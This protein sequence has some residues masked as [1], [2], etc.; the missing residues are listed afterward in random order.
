MS[1][2][3][4]CRKPC[5]GAAEFCESC[6]SLLH[7]QLWQ[8]ASTVR[9]IDPPQAAES[10]GASGASLER[11]TAPQAL[12]DASLLHPEMPVHEQM[13]DQVFQQLHAAARQL[14]EAGNHRR[15]P[16]APRLSPLRDISIEIQRHSTPLRRVENAPEQEPGEEQA[17]NVYERWPLP[18]IDE[19]DEDENDIWSNHTDPLIRRH[20][21]N[22]AEVTRIEE[23]DLQRAIAEGLA[24]APLLA[25][26]ALPRQRT[27]RVAFAIFLVLAAAFLI[28]DSV[29]LF[30]VFAHPQRNAATHNGPPSLILSANVATAG[31]SLTLHIRHF[32]AQTRVY[33]THDIQESLQIIR[34]SSLLAVDASGS[35][36]V[37]MLVDATW[38]PGF[39]TIEA[40]DVATRYTASATLQIAGAGPTRPAHLLIDSTTLDLGAD[41][42]GANTL[43]T[44]TL[45]NSG[46]GSISWSASSNQAWLL[47]S[48]PQG[49]F[50][51]SQTIT[52]AVERANLKPG[53][54]KGTITF[55]SNV[56]ASEFVQVQMTVRPLPANV[57]PFLQLTP[58]V[59]SFTALDGGPSP[60]NQSLMISNPGTQ[61]LYWSLSSNNQLDL[62]SMGLA[63]NGLDP[64]TGWLTL[65]Q[66]SGVVVPHGSSLISA[67]VNSH[68]LLPGV[69]TDLLVF[70]AGH[71]VIDSP[72]RVSVSLTVQPHCGLTLNAGSIA[73]TAV[74][75]QSN[76]SNQAVGLGATSSCAGVINWRAISFANWL[77]ATPASGQLKG[78][79]NAVSA[80]S[81]SAS[82]LRP[83][84]Y[85]STLDFVTAQSTHTLSVQ[86]TVQ[87]PPS[88]SAPIMGATPL[89]LNFST[90]QGMPNP[91]GQTVTITNTGRSTLGWHTVVSSMATSWLVTSPAGGSIPAGQ[92]VQLTININTAGLSPNTYMGQVVL[93]GSDANGMAAAGT[94]QTITVNLQVLPPCALQ[95]PSL[96]SMAFS[97]TQGNADP[98]PQPMVITATGNC[99]W[100]LS[101]HATIANAPTWLSLS[102]TAGSFTAS[103]QSI[104]LQVAAS[105]AGLAAGTYTSKV[106]LRA[107][108]SS[109]TSVI[110]TPRVFS[111]TLTVLPP[112]T[113][114]MMGA[115]NFSFSVPQGQASSTPQSFAFSESGT[116]AGPLGWTASGDAGSSD[117]LILAPTSGSGRGSVT[118]SVN[119]QSFAPGTYLGTVTLTAI[120]SGGAVV[121]GSPQSIPVTLTVTGYGLSGTV[122]ACSDTSCTSSQPLPGASLS[123]VNSVNQAMTVV[124]DNAGNYSFS[125]LALG[126][127]TLT[128]SGSAGTTSYKGS[129]SLSITGN[130][131]NFSIQC[132]PLVGP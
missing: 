118:V 54:Y 72:Q 116:C 109:N 39:H 131:T 86:L 93:N 84:T 99:S 117:W 42:Q 108:D 5:E 48:P 125:N 88:P 58:P 94:P 83:G 18:H 4:R 25:R 20:F 128:V 11:V 22:S 91:P 77:T 110:G 106:T 102:A 37:A 113:L 87:A 16:R 17:S 111:V 121:Q 63:L 104:S 64:R 65:D 56:G 66:S 68:N 90:T 82:I 8:Q 122:L 53:D 120:G 7:D 41:W 34:G 60:N 55:S 27:L 24:T 50:S 35:A 32:S 89:Q 46:G 123:L 44:L 126:S 23:E 47:L 26:R 52:V 74:S 29:L 67:V 105:V 80:I 114:H 115:T 75:G 73:F 19:I 127:Y 49:M 1:R 40:E 78:S 97:A 15:H 98:G 2:C 12:V 36:D 33:L 14:L 31:Q 101:W 21:P 38:E 45:R 107:G 70:A 95:Q 132:L 119:A 130:L 129:A 79:A 81:V 30:A 3:L 9:E 57:G 85:F 10:N 96:S 100:P 71:S 124:A 13:V 112:C 103:S 92:N 51:Q 61:P 69:Y 62:S 6:R 59:I 28:A 76:P 43:H